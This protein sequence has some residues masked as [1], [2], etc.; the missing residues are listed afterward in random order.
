M[1]YVIVQFLVLWAIIPLLLFFNRKNSLIV[2][3]AYFLVL[4]FLSAIA[5][6]QYDFDINTKDTLNLFV[7]VVWGILIGIGST[8]V[9]LN[10]AIP[11]MNASNDS[12]VNDLVKASEHYRELALY[13]LAQCVLFLIMIILYPI[14]DYLK[15]LILNNNA[16]LYNFSRSFYDKLLV[17]L[18]SSLGVC[19]LLV[20]FWA[21]YISY[22][23]GQSKKVKPKP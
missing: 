7:S 10:K 18:V 20:G 13:N 4:P 17:S 16:E 1:T 23:L 8:V 2:F 12:D 15:K 19:A 11:E 9:F 14:R 3:A 22:Q 6:Y 5:L 21:I